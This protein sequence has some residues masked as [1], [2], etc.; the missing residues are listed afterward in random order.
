MLD[1]GCSKLDLI[2]T[3]PFTLPRNI[4]NLLYGLF[5]QAKSIN[6]FLITFQLKTGFSLRY[7]KHPETSIQHHGLSACNSYYS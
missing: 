5:R 3:L 2:K 1:T 6:E 4:I 7:N